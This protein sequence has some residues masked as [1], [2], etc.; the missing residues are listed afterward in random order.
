MMYLLPRLNHVGISWFDRR[1]LLAHVVR[2]NI[3]VLELF[4]MQC[5]RRV[6]LLKRFFGGTHILAL[7]VHVS[8]GHFIRLGVVFVDVLHGE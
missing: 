3:N 7:L 6:A 2:A 1:R 4:S 8:F 5:C